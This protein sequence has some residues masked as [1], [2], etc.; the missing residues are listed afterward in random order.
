MKENDQ[1]Y[2]GTYSIK[3]A[4]NF[5]GMSYK[6]AGIEDTLE[7]FE[8]SSLEREF[9]KISEEWNAGLFRYLEECISILNTCEYCVLSSALKRNEK[10]LF[11][12]FVLLKQIKDNASA[13]RLLSSIGLDS[14]SRIILRALYE[15]SIA[16]SR[17]VIDEN[18]RSK[19]QLVNSPKESNK[20][21]FEF[22]KGSKSEDYLKNYN[23][24]APN[25]KK[26]L[27]VLLE[28]IDELYK[29][30]GVSA[31]PNYFGSVIEYTESIK[32][33]QNLDS[34]FPGSNSATEF[35]LVNSCLLSLLNITFLSLWSEE[36]CRNTEWI[37][38]LKRFDG[39]EKNKEVL[40]RFGIVSN[41]MIHMLLK[42]SNRQKKDFNPDIHY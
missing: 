25:N 8:I 24:T 34:I 5:I 11:P 12:I 32:S 37:F 38:K 10:N 20:F 18:F 6:Q 29:I 16:F 30:L 7:S 33:E 17:S 39:F 23:T 3:L 13:I 21:W 1:K 22:M 36:I 2:D 4:R 27:I 19:F 9:G 35:V 15:N 14:Q 42:W 40:D 28:H 31:H 26:C 41:F